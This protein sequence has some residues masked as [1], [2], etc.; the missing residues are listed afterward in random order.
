MRETTHQGPVRND[1]GV[2]RAR[3]AAAIPPASSASRVQPTSTGSERPKS[4][5]AE[6]DATSHL[7]GQGHDE[8]A[9][10]ESQPVS[11]STFVFQPEQADILLVIALLSLGARQARRTVHLAPAPVAVLRAL[12]PLHVRPDMYVFLNTDRTPIAPNNFLHTSTTSN[13][14]VTSACADCTR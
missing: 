11:G 12:C 4:S 3:T 2:A 7:S 5:Y 14:H 10:L 13:G 8:G 9:A 1:H 6:R